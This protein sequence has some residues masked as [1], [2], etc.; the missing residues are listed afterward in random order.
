MF[1]DC[2]SHMYIVKK[3]DPEQVS[4]YRPISILSQFDKIMEKFSYNR[5]TPELPKRS[6]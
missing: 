4:N 3:G 1:K 2:R 5:L 6:F